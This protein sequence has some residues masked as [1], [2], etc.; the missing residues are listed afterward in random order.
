MPSL[1]R[2]V[3]KPLKVPSLA[4]S[5]PKP[6]LIFAVVTIRPCEII[7]NTFLY[8]DVNWFGCSC[9]SPFESNYLN[10]LFLLIYYC[11]V[12]LQLFIQIERK[13]F[14]FFVEPIF[15]EY[16]WVFIVHNLHLCGKINRKHTN[17]QSFEIRFYKQSRW[18]IY[19]MYMEWIFLSDLRGFIP[20]IAQY[21]FVRENKQTKNQTSA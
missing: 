2:S 17:K 8:E 16:V 15:L 11:L 20:N 3:P 13:L 19:F 5:V 10:A 4:R 12:P 21:S 7:L 18:H 14:F 1:A 6:L 9:L